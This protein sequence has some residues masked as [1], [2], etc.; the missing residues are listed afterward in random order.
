[1]RSVPYDDQ[2]VT[3]ARVEN[4]RGT[5]ALRRRRPA[6]NEPCQARQPAQPAQPGGDVYELIVNGTFAMD[7][8]ETSTER[9]LART[10]LDRI[11]RPATVA[12]G[13]LGLG[14]TVAE[15][16]TDDRVE[17]V[18]V[19]ELEPA[20]LE[21]VAAGLVPPTAHVLADGRVHTHAA[22]IADWV[23]RR[24]AGSVDVL[25]LDVDNGPD[26]LI[27]QAN[28][29]LYRGPFL[30]RARGALRSGGCLLVWSADPSEPLRHAL[31]EAF[32]TCAEIPA[33]VRRQDRSI[34]YVVYF[35]HVQ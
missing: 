30:R 13:G 23:E 31:A 34:D 35:C 2:P 14:F 6:P 9:L 16:L 19:V 5:L 27:H 32:G 28:A 20:V 29:A 24:T 11:E 12:V 10:A 21:W 17:R 33:T 4:E 25:L 26:F 22:D 8:A 7:S 18:E 3:L 15:L 1:M